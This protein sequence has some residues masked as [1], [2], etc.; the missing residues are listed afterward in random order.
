M[1][2]GVLDR[3]RGV[4]HEGQGVVVQRLS[5]VGMAERLGVGGRARQRDRPP[6]LGRSLHRQAEPVSMSLLHAL[7][8]ASAFF[9][10]QRRVENDGADAVAEGGDD[11]GHDQAT[12]GVRH[13]RHRAGGRAGVDV[14][15]HRCGFLL[16]RQRGQDGWP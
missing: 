12:R 7:D 9:G 11:T 4:D 5:A 2:H 1:V 16:H 14:G 6:V 13:Q 15:R 10:H 8:P 3:T